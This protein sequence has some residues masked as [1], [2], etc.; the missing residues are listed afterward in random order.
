MKGLLS[1]GPTPSSFF[2]FNWF[3]NF[4]YEKLF[5]YKVKT[6]RY[7]LLCGPSFWSFGLRPRICLP[8]GQ[9][10][11]FCAL[12]YCKPFLVYSSNQSHFE[13]IPKNNIYI[14]PNPKRLTKYSICLFF[15][16]ILKQYSGIF[17]KCFPLNFAILGKYN[18]TIVLQSTPL[19]N[20]GKVPRAWHKKQLQQ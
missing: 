10:R 9:K 18:L 17:L 8:V 6:R 14:S 7:G 19:Q 13:N 5:L 3:W 2:N 1:T 20:P 12:L 15:F 16:F 11:T 4:R